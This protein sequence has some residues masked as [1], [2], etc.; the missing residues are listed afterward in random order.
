MLDFSNQSLSLPGAEGAAGKSLRCPP[1]SV[2]LQGLCRTPLPVAALRIPAL[3]R[4]RHLTAVNFVG[5]GFSPRL[6]LF[7]V[8]FDLRRSLFAGCLQSC[9]LLIS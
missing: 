1:P 5:W 6:R 2:L 4:K 7:S 3:F 9:L 8:A